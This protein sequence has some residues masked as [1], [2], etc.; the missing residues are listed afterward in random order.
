MV[1]TGHLD[2]D[3]SHMGTR[4]L[5]ALTVQFATSIPKTALANF[6]TRRF[7]RQPS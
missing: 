6:G 1:D 7:M 2:V 4:V 3:V 5:V